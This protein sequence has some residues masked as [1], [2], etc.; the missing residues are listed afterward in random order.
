[1]TSSDTLDVGSFAQTAY[2][3]IDFPMPLHTSPGSYRY[4]VTVAGT[5]TCG[6]DPTKILT[7]SASREITVEMPD[8][9]HHPPGEPL[10]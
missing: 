2:L 5:E 8:T 7:A 9:S 6:T 4:V 1:V 10:G 3:D